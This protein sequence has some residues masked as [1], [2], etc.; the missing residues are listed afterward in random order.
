[1]PTWMKCS[2]EN[3][4]MGTTTYVFV[5]LD[6]VTHVT[7]GVK[8]GSVLYFSGQAKDV[9]KVRETP[10]TIANIGKSAPVRTANLVAS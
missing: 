2:Q 8:G 9:L 6:Q 7:D 10:E 5:N 1:M 3:E 4:M